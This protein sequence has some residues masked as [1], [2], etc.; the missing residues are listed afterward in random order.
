MGN[1]SMRLGRKL[2]WD[3]EKEEFADDKE[4]NAMRSREMRKPWD[5][6]TS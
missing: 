3:P 2:Q 1:I 4:A 5:L 6:A